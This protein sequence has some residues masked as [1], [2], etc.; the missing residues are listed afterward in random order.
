MTSAVLNPPTGQAAVSQLSAPSRLDSVVFFGLFGLLLFGP[1]AFGSVEPWSIFILEAGAAILFLLWC[2]RQI[3]SGEIAIS[4]SPLFAPM[5]AFAGLIATQLASGH[6]AYPYA[7]YSWALLYCAYGL[8]CFLAVQV[9]RRTSQVKKLTW[10]FSAY[11]FGVALFALIQGM[12]SPTRLYG[13]RTPRSG[14]WIYGPYVNHN[15]YAGLMEML[16]PIP[17]VFALSRFAQGPRRMMAAVAAAVI[18]GTIFLSGSRGGML[19]FAVQMAVLIALLASKEKGRKAAIAFGIFLTITI[20]LLAWLGGGEL[21]KRMASIHS[22]TRSELSGGLRMAINRDGLRM[23]LHKPVLGWGLGT[24]PE[25]YPQFRTFYTNFFINQAHDDYIQLLVEM[26][27]FGF[28]AML[29]FLV[30]MFRQALKKLAQWPE[31]VN[32]TVALAALLGIIGILVH[33]FVD[34]NLEIPANAALFYVLCTV[35]ALDARFTPPRRR[36]SRRRIVRHE[37]LPVNSAEE[38]K[39]LQ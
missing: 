36:M 24:F 30:A 8:L 11:G 34:F 20:G 31:N 33:S 21:T 10:M 7:T 35:A 6:T 1:L 4:G 13:I 39:L 23:F 19:A 12:G 2:I 14:G 17:L 15:H 18:A 9:V 27:V 37:W 16:L 38:E 5:L 28:A 29:W 25:V 3:Q 32:G 22:E 26:G